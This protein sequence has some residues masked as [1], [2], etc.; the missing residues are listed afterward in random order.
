[1]DSASKDIRTMRLS[2]Q[3]SRLPRMTFR[4]SSSSLLI[5]VCAGGDGCAAAGSAAAAAGV[6]GE[7]CAAAAAD[8]GE[9]AGAE[10]V[11]VI[12]AAAS[13]DEGS[14][15][16]VSGMGEIGGLLAGFCGIRLDAAEPASNGFGRRCMTSAPLLATMPRSLA[17]R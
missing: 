16:V 6:S 14:T 10:A 12:A 8:G 4:T 9:A 7:C 15:R 1:M 11:G 13:W 3:L 5:E 17:A 2:P